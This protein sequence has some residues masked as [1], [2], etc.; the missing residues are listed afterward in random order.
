MDLRVL[1]IGGTGFISGY[2]TR[3]LLADR[4]QVAIF[5]R[6][7]TG[8]DVGAQVTEIFGDRHELPSYR[9]QFQKFSPGVVIDTIGLT[10]E[11]GHQLTE[12]FRGLAQRTVVIS[13]ADVYRSY[14]LL[15]GIGDDVPDPAPLRETSPLRTKLFPYRSAAKDS[16]DRFYNYDKILVESAVMADPDL[17]ATVLRLPA[18]YGPG[19]KQR[20]LFPVLKRMDDK[21]P[22]ILLE[23]EWVNWKWTRGYVENV[24]AVICAAVGDENSS[25]R[26]YNVGEHRGLS[27]SEWIGSIAAEVGWKGRIV[28]VEPTDLPEQMRSKLSWKHHLETDTTLIRNL[29][30]FSEPVSFAEG[31][32]KSIHWE[33]R[34]PPAEIKAEDFDYAAEDRVLAKLG[35]ETSDK[36]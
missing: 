24:A 20:R 27:Q 6:G 4:H 23:R 7:A 10:E 22:A 35:F 1:V 28:A 8:S 12:T 17:P 9:Q 36:L 33:R 3:R 11:D 5:H 19:D 25:G 34:N 13:S 18:V 32:R 14:E 29:N 26:I 15:R 31:L 21:R 16:S 30:G 2:V